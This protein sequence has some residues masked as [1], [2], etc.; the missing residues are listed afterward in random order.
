MPIIHTFRPEGLTSADLICVARATPRV[1]VVF[2]VG[3]GPSPSFRV[4][5]LANEHD[6]GH[7]VSSSALSLRHT[8]KIVGLRIYPPFEGSEHVKFPAGW[9]CLYWL[10][11]ST[12]GGE[13]RYHI[14]APLD[15]D[16][17]SWTR[18]D[19]EER[20]SNADDFYIR[21][22]VPWS[23]QL[24]SAGMRRIARKDGLLVMPQTLGT[25][26]AQHPRERSLRSNLD[27]LF[28][29]DHGTSIRPRKSRKSQFTMANSDEDALILHKQDLAP[30]KAY[31][32]GAKTGTGVGAGAV[33]ERTGDDRE[34]HR[35]TE[36]V[37]VGRK[38]HY[39]AHDAEIIGLGISLS[40]ASRE[41]FVGDLSLYSDSKVALQAVS[42]AARHCRKWK[43][44]NFVLRHYNLLVRRHPTARVTFRWIPGH[45][46]VDGHNNADRLAREAA[47]GGAANRLTP[48]RA[49]LDEYLRWRRPTRKE[50]SAARAVRKRRNI[51]NY[52]FS[53][54]MEM[55]ADPVSTH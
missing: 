2:A 12:G 30:L 35:V 50:R 16:A 20:F 39:S 14:L 18:E 42:T 52:D 41:P 6:D 21:P 47:A 37:Y 13:I 1:N 5:K 7:H 9:A 3:Y 33:L 11:F 23:C 27:A 51:E 8:N 44:A 45:R 28:H 43:L 22:G 36:R 25:H 19:L 34:V 46:D 38:T 26:V 40:L 53:E 24:F 54:L 55:L 49:R 17:R 32:D 4:Y 10:P 48:D 29:I 31:S 15:E